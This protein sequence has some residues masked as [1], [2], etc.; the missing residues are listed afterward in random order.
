MISVSTCD[1]LFVADITARLKH[2]EFSMV[3]QYIRSGMAV[4]PKASGSD[5]VTI[6]I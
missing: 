2:F 1:V 4:R 3:V 5:M 6:K